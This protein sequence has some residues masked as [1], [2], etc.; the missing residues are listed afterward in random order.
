VNEAVARRIHEKVAPVVTWLR[1][2]E[3]ESDEEEEEDGVEVVY[4]EAAS[5]TGIITE[6]VPNEEVCGR[7]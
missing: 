3:E 4:T 2:A 7:G 5:K 1:T 6:T